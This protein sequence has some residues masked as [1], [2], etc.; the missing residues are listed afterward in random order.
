MAVLF[1]PMVR[2]APEPQCQ[3]Q[4]LGGDST[5]R[6]Q[7]AYRVLIVDDRAELRGMLR[8]RLNS[9]RDIEV[10]GEAGNGEEAVRLTRALA[11]SAV[12]LDLDM[13]V[14]RGD[15][16]IPLMREAAPGMGILLYTGTDGAILAEE[17]APDVIVG[18][19]VPLTE[20]V[21]Q[22]HALLQS[23]PSAV[24]PLTVRPLPLRQAIGAFAS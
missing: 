6:E 10:V 11:P 13:P 20:V 23:A 21:A 5:G 1:Q 12:V 22:L 14:M 18:K 16:A 8:A 3:T 4:L 24:L 15:E 17:A 19:G 9:E 7:S 2:G